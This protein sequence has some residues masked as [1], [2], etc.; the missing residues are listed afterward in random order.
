MSQALAKGLDRE[1]V[2]A[3]LTV[4]TFVVACKMYNHFFAKPKETY[5][6]IDITKMTIIGIF[7][8]FATRAAVTC[9]F[10]RRIDFASSLEA[11]S[12]EDF[13]KLPVMTRLVR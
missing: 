1:T 12:S 11:P 5:S 8:V 6:D 10:E 3:V 7:A 9:L 4:V 2:I 13:P